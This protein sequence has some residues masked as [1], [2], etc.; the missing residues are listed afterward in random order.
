MLPPPPQYTPPLHDTHFQ[1]IPLNTH[2]HPHI[3]FNLFFNTL[4]TS[5]LPPGTAT[6]K[7]LKD[8][9]QDTLRTSAALAEFTLTLPSPVLNPS[10]APPAASVMAI[11]AGKAWDSNRWTYSHIYTLHPLSPPL[12]HLHPHLHPCLYHTAFPAPTLQYYPSILLLYSSPLLLLPFSPPPPPLF[13]DA[14]TGLIA[15]N[16]SASSGAICI[17]EPKALRRVSNYTLQP[18]IR[19]DRKL[20]IKLDIKHKPL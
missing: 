15:I 18:D 9:A 2:S 16:C 17:H 8:K 4:S 11:D 10:E 3:T 6:S 7:E 12:T 13:D 5:S 20:G 19:L 14:D 1:C